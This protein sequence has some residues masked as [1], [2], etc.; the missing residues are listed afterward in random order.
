MTFFKRDIIFLSMIVAPRRRFM[1]LT[2]TSDKQRFNVAASRAKNQMRLYHSIDLE[3]LNPDDLR[4]RLL[5]YC[6]IPNR[7]SEQ[8][9]DLE[10]KCDSP[11]EKDVLRMILA[12]GYKV[13]PQVVVG[14]YRIDFVIEG[15]RDQDYITPP[16]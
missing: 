16:A 8:F 13:T 10:D 6:N 5:S 12:R 1:A 4:Y 7:T 14:R 3:D 11:F 2:K 15:I 9:E